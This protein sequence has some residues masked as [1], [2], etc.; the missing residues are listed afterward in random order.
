MFEGKRTQLHLE[1]KF[2]MKPKKE[3]KILNETLVFYLLVFHQ[4]FSSLIWNKRINSSMNIKTS[5]EKGWEKIIKEKVREIKDN[6]S[7][8][9][10]EL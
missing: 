6:C 7:A 2:V 10:R 3:K 5:K 1:P 9:H 8:S 4:E